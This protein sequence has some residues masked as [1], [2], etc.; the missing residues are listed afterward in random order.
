M[1]KKM[2][3]PDYCSPLLTGSIGTMVFSFIISIVGGPNPSHCLN[4]L[5]LTL[6]LI[7]AIILARNFF[8]YNFIKKI[9]LL[10]LLII[11]L[12]VG[13]YLL[14]IKYGYINRRYINP[15]LIE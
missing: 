4:L 12:T 13:T 2:T 10:F 1:F 5:A 15:F 7:A 14:Y 11:S 6:T 9:S 3:E 8:Y